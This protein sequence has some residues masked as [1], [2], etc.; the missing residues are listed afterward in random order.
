MAKATIAY[1]WASGQI[2]FGTDCP[3]G[4]IPIV[5]GPG[6]KVR[7]FICA[8]S[9]HAYDGKTLLVPGIPEAPNQNAAGDALDRFITWIKP[10]L[11]KSGLRRAFI[12]RRIEP[13]R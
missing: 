11:A 9:R 6:R 12:A 3:D 1:C 2:D 13:V 7:D 8:V 10:M 5:K 4:A